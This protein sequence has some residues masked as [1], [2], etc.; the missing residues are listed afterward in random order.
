MNGN[1][2]GSFEMNNLGGRPDEDA[3]TENKQDTTQ[4]PAAPKPPAAQ[5]PAEQPTTTWKPAAPN[6]PTAPLQ[7]PR[8][9]S[10]PIVNR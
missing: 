3:N 10:H 4:Q 8:K 6:A 9:E 7:G 1:P 2:G 5:P